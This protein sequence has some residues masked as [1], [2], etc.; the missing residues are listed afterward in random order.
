MANNLILQPGFVFWDGLKYI[1]TPGTNANATGPAGGDLLGNY[2]NPTVA[3]I[4]SVPVATTTPAQG[5]V[6]VF[7]TS[8]AKYD[9][10]QLTLDDLG[11]AFSITSFSG[12]STVEVGATVT[13]PAFT[14]SYSSPATSANITNTDN[15]DSPLT[16][17]TPFTSGTVV[18]SFTHT[19]ITSVTFTLTAIAAT[20]KTATQAINY[21][22]RSFSGLGGTGAS[23]ATGATASGTNATLVGG[24]GTTLTGTSSFGGL[25]SSVVGQSFGLFTPVNQKIYILTP[26]TGSPHTFKDQNGFGFPFD[27]GGSPTTF[28]FTNV[29]GTVLSYD[30]YESTNLLSTN[31]TLTVVS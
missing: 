5:A 23:G 17:I 26:H 31:F 6:I 2:P 11:P 30:L 8:A 19:T 9:I 10:R 16:L 27:G 12:G 28:S 4:Q 1:T 24:G 15:I 25:F 3:R 18:G 7:D 14:A 13:N 20:T 21:F 22:G 29:N